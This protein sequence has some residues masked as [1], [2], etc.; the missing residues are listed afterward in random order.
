[1]LNLEKLEKHVDY[2]RKTHFEN[3]KENIDEFIE[4]QLKKASTNF[5]IC[6]YRFLLLENVL[7]S[8]KNRTKR[9]EEIFKTLNNIVSAGEFINEKILEFL[10]EEQISY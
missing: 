6:F 10:N 3:P 2:Y 9:Q 8:L 7:V 4:K 1:M 5:L